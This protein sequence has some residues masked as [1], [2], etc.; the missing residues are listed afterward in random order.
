MEELFMAVVNARPA[1]RLDDAE[2]ALVQLRAIVDLTEKTALRE[3][4]D[5]HI[6]T[7]AKELGMPPA[8]LR[9]Q[10][11]DLVTEAKSLNSRAVELDHLLDP[12]R[13]DALSQTVTDAR[14]TGRLTDAQ[15]ALDE[16]RDIITAAEEAS[17]TR[18]PQSDQPVITD[19]DPDQNGA[20][21]AVSSPVPQTPATATVPALSPVQGVEEAQHKPTERLYTEVLST[22]T[23]A[24]PNVS[25]TTGLSIAD[26]L[27]GVTPPTP[28]RPDPTTHTSTGPDDFSLQTE[29]NAPDTTTV[30]GTP[31]T[32]PDTVH[33]LLSD[34]HGNTGHSDNTEATRAQMPVGSGADPGFA[35]ADGEGYAR[36]IHKGTGHRIQDLWDLASLV[37]AARR[38][39]FTIGS[40]LGPEELREANLAHY[41]Q[42]IAT[43][44]QL[45][46]LLSPGDRR[47]VI[48]PATGLSVP[49]AGPDSEQDLN[50]L[51]DVVDTAALRDFA[52]GPHQQDAG[53]GQRLART[54]TADI[55]D[56]TAGWDADSPLGYWATAAIAQRLAIH[57]GPLT[58]THLADARTLAQRIKD[59]I[60][61]SSLPTSSLRKQSPVRPPQGTAPWS[62]VTTGQLRS[63]GAG[64]GAGPDE[65]GMRALAKSGS[66]VASLTALQELAAV[67]DIA[68]LRAFEAGPY[69]SLDAT[70]QI[71]ARKIVAGTMRFDLTIADA[72]EGLEERDPLR[73]WT[74]V[75]IAYALTMAPD[76]SHTSAT[77]LAE[78]IRQTLRLPKPQGLP[79]GMRDQNDQIPPRDGEASGQGTTNPYMAASHISEQARQVIGMEYLD[80]ALGLAQVPQD[81]LDE[82]DVRAAELMLGY[83]PN[84]AQLPFDERQPRVDFLDAL[85]RV[86]YALYLGRGGDSPEA[87]AV[88]VVQYL[89]ARYPQGFARQ[90]DHVQDSQSVDET[91]VGST[92]SPR[93][94]AHRYLPT[95]NSGDDGFDSDPMVLDGQEPTAGTVGGDDVAG[96]LLFQSGDLVQTEDLSH[97]LFEPDGFFSSDDSLVQF[98]GDSSSLDLPFLTDE[99]DEPTEPPVFTE[100]TVH[101]DHAFGTH[102]AQVV[103]G[104]RDG[105]E[106]VELSSR[107]GTGLRGTQRATGREGG[108]PGQAGTRR[109]H[110]HSD[111][112]QT[113]SV[114]VRKRRRTRGGGAESSQSFRH[115]AF[116][117]TSLGHLIASPPLASAE[118]DI[119][120]SEVGNANG[121]GTSAGSTSRTRPS[122]QGT[123]TEWPVTNT[124]HTLPGRYRTGDPVTRFTN[125]LSF[126]L[127]GLPEA[128]ASL[129]ELLTFLVHYSLGLAQDN[130]WNSP[131]DLVKRRRPNHPVTL[132]EEG[133]HLGIMQA[134]ALPYVVGTRSAIAPGTVQEMTAVLTAVHRAK[135]S[136]QPLDH[137][138]L[139]GQT[140]PHAGPALLAQATGWAQGAELGYAT[141]DL[142]LLLTA[143]Q[144]LRRSGTPTGTILASVFYNSRPNEFQR[145]A[146]DHLLVTTTDT[147]PAPTNQQAGP[148]PPSGATDRSLLAL[149]LSMELA[150]VD[151]YADD[152]LDIDLFSTPGDTTDI[153][154]ER[155]ATSWRRPPAPLVIGPKM[156]TLRNTVK[157][158]TYKGDEKIVTDSDRA[159]AV[160]LISLSRTRWDSEVNRSLY[161]KHLVA[162]L[163]KTSA[164]MRLGGMFLMSGAMIQGQGGSSTGIMM[165]DQMENVVNLSGMAGGDE[166]AHTVNDIVL[167]TWPVNTQKRAALVEG[168]RAMMDWR[169]GDVL[170]ALAEAVVEIARAMKRTGMSVDEY[171]I[172]SLI[173]RDDRALEYQVI[174]VR[175]I[176]EDWRVEIDRVEEIPGESTGVEDSRTTAVVQSTWRARRNLWPV[177]PAPLTVG[178]KLQ[179]L[180]DAVEAFSYKGGELLATDDDRANL[181]LMISLDRTKDALGLNRTMYLRH[182]VP[183]GG[184]DSARAELMGYFRPGGAYI[185]EK[186]YGGYEVMSSVQMAQIM[187]LKDA[188]GANGRPLT[189]LEAARQVWGP[190]VSTRPPVVAAVW[191]M[192]GWRNGGALQLLAEA[193]VEIAVDMRRHNI[194]VGP[195]L[196]AELI[197]RDDRALAYQVVMVQ[198][199]LRD[200]RAEIEKDFDPSS[201]EPHQQS[202]D[203]P[204][205][206]DEPAHPLTPPAPEHQTA[207]QE[208]QT[209]DP[210]T[211]SSGT[212]HSVPTN[213]SPRA[214][215]RVHPT[216]WPAPPGP[217]TIGSKLQQLRNMALTFTYTG[218]EPSSTEQEQADIVLLISL[219]RT[220]TDRGIKRSVY[221]THLIPDLHTDTASMWLAGQFITLGATLAE[222]KGTGDLITP[223]Q[224]AQVMAL[225][226]QPGTSFTVAKSLWKDTLVPKRNS[227]VA[228]VW[229]AMNWGGGGAAQMLAEAVVEIAVDMKHHGMRV[230]AGLIAGLI[231][232]DN[233]ALA[234][235]VVVVE[236]ILHDRSAEIGDDVDLSDAHATE[237]PQDVQDSSAA[238]DHQPASSPGAGPSI[239]VHDGSTGNNTQTTAVRRRSST[240]PPT[241]LHEADEQPDYSMDIE[242]LGPQHDHDDSPEHLTTDDQLT[243]GHPDIPNSPDPAPHNPTPTPQGA[244]VSDPQPS[245]TPDEGS[246]S[247]QEL[248]RYLTQL[249][250]PM[251]PLPPDPTPEAQLVHVLHAVMTEARKG[252]HLPIRDIAVRAS[253]AAGQLPSRS[254][255]LRLLGT[256]QSTGLPYVE[257]GSTSNDTD[258]ATPAGP[259]TPDQMTVLLAM[260]RTYWTSGRSFDPQNLI[261][262][263][264][265]TADAELTAQA[266]GWLLGARLLRLTEPLPQTL[267]AAARVVT[268]NG[269]TANTNVISTTLMGGGPPT[270]FRQAAFQHWTQL[271]T[272]PVVDP[273]TTPETI[274]GQ[275]PLAVRNRLTRLSAWIRDTPSDSVPSRRQLGEVLT[276]VVLRALKGAANGAPVTAAELV[277]GTNE[278]GQVGTAAEEQLF[279]GML[280]AMALP[281]V[282]RGRGPTPPGT[283][284]EMGLILTAVAQAVT[285]GQL[286]RPDILVAQVLPYADPELKA[287][288]FGWIMGAQLAFAGGEVSLLV[289]TVRQLHYSGAGL[290]AIAAT[291]FHSSQHTD[292]QEVALGHLIAPGAAQSSHGTQPP[293]QNNIRLHSHNAATT[294][295]SR[296][297]PPDPIDDFNAWVTSRVSSLLSD[298]P[299][300]SQTLGGVFHFAWSRV[301]DDAPIHVMDVII[302]R[303]GPDHIIQ[304]GDESLT[305]GIVQA[306]GLR[307]TGTDT[308][309]AP[310]TAAQMAE[311]LA[312]LRR[313]WQAGGPIVADLLIRDTLPGADPQLLAQARGWLYSGALLRATGN[314]AKIISAARHLRPPRADT[315][316]IAHTLLN[317]SQPDA[318]QRAAIEHWI[319]TPTPTPTQP[320]TEISARNAQRWYRG[321]LTTNNRS[322]TTN[323]DSS[324]DHPTGPHLTTSPHADEA[325]YGDRPGDSS[326]YQLGSGVTFE[327]VHPRRSTGHT[328]LP[329]RPTTPTPPTKSNHTTS[330]GWPVPLTSQ[331]LSRA[332]RL[333]YGAV[334]MSMPQTARDVLGTTDPAAVVRLH[335]HL[336]T[337]SSRY[338]SHHAAARTTITNS[339]DTLQALRDHAVGHGLHPDTGTW[340][341][342][343]HTHHTHHP[344]PEP[345]A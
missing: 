122:G 20:G 86:Q 24:A 316:A 80:V 287:Q 261:Q 272:A 320:A 91:V 87:T 315:M 166:E 190:K 116:Q 110:A 311:I 156:Q 16:L 242:P 50:R 336:L 134:T 22:P 179:Q 192:M 278:A 226:N 326:V 229:A 63:T 178:S 248:R 32:G 184:E 109:E 170:Q 66:S 301:R 342:T 247:S 54:L 96:P 62:E 161:M 176:L 94:A 222:R 151:L 265:P 225:K 218:N 75:A 228:G 40:G 260:A 252:V 144:H 307:P 244:I 249:D 48:A 201:D 82:L 220:Y 59:H 158:F 227:V 276:S 205:P 283:A 236:A 70:Q 106:A 55:Y 33:A 233:R 135:A 167:R 240:S 180:R 124:G 103:E 251:V 148:I 293:V 4:L 329:S 7:A 89:A 10:L 198:A 132:D 58:P 139:A 49:P 246:A 137:A 76:R 172:A 254:E 61:D 219:S 11:D 136:R 92:Q 175:A 196:I 93:A 323:P 187:A 37:V 183:D 335:D 105:E 115:A 97:L 118:D 104:A 290:A 177:P 340:W 79:G 224:L 12:A 337:H 332:E 74:L 234:Y 296:T 314:A 330:I 159:N 285:T 160:L 2:A 123:D 313:A 259:G 268:E 88:D 73:Y 274:S 171:L 343:H 294:P 213:P 173:W 90:A 318:F 162:G 288:A 186:K 298:D 17:R 13:T 41:Q 150:E 206:T 300:V 319:T 231:W 57:P 189:A 140:L 147:P 207:V 238:A 128:N 52:A 202:Q 266:S 120:N 322:T 282:Y 208:P 256:M 255:E 38:P 169:N 71:A 262:Q 108:V 3:P 149:S 100:H 304:P 18:Y 338:R 9:Q 143:V 146:L 212:P 111:D 181:S 312:A 34:H 188:L 56:N 328:P 44:Q 25:V 241:P 67:I 157:S 141:G 270:R 15:T 53:A 239:H 95:T 345:P 221:I 99:P 271:F 182:L 341:H 154:P 324:S 280:Q 83:F 199:I 331:D 289:L 28:Q 303:H 269:L 258:A 85:F 334:P 65:A 45:N 8:Q 5:Q 42:V 98:L 243:L 191:A 302:Y 84:G 21:P 47:S 295:S 27:S 309:A 194:Q 77:Q 223:V 267:T 163:A 209:T 333:L 237:S 210:H 81:V 185:R 165:P 121:S 253:T 203:P 30:H 1:G 164:I 138:A 245:S 131:E 23:D 64:A 217:L 325:N 215:T 214:P 168:V 69:H 230:D 308:G 321:I 174:I 107:S 257:M 327:R 216:D 101:T 235:Q 211:D 281:H 68:T 277:T 250:Q 142:G 232:R 275:P 200:H 78:K 114:P 279:L 204:T 19:P 344:T 297:Q 29:E 6:D 153:Q 263:T 339:T 306:L 113:P 51:A 126:G 299:T 43:A 273:S 145:A 292:F 152:L 60:Q 305:F 193:V 127:V 102:D 39:E 317:T 72:G 117:E 35:G 197:W 125:W 264:F 130:I 284:R 195:D 112:D 129:N 310:G 46:P 286:F 119:T 31:L 155:S 291:V 133:L 36:R 14:R 26:I